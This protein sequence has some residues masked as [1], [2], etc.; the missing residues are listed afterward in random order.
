MAPPHSFGV[1]VRR[2]LACLVALAAALSL[3][4]C[5]DQSTATTDAQRGSASTAPLAPTATPAWRVDPTG[6][7]A[8]STGRLPDRGN[9]A[10]L[11]V[12]LGTT[13]A[14]LSGQVHGDRWLPTLAGPTLTVTSAGSTVSV[15]LR[16][17][18]M[19]PGR[20]TAYVP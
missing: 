10:R 14:V 7:V 16:A 11:E 19:G 13:T 6:N 17:P 8:C 15:V 5:G 4:A 3:S 12:R 2:P 1:V 9:Q 18:R 20:P